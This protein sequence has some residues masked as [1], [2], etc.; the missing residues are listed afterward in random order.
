MNKTALGIM[1]GLTAGVVDVVP[2]IIQKLPLEADLSAFSAWVVIGFF[3]AR[4]DLKLP[5]FLKGVAVAFLTVIP[6]LTL[7]GFKEPATLIP[8]LVMTL[9]LGSLSGSFIHKFGR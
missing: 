6:V 9:V 8:I 1:T 5:G 4:I 2:M 7:V 3:I